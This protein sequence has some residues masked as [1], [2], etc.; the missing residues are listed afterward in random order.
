MRRKESKSPSNRTEIIT[1]ENVHRGSG[2]SRHAIGI[3]EMFDHDRHTNGI[4]NVS[5]GLLSQV[6]HRE[7]NR[8]LVGRLLRGQGKELIMQT[9]PNQTKTKNRSQSKQNEGTKGKT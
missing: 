5:P 8:R 6:S 4:V 1:K 9:K 7:L 3:S 2:Q